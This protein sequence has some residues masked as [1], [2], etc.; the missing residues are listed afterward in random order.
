MEE[1]PFVV[2][3]RNERSDDSATS[4]RVHAKRMSATVVK[5]PA[6]HASL[7]SHPNEIAELIIA[8]AQSVAK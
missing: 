5:V 7:V 3:G 6:G 4:G 2:H 8:A 1:S